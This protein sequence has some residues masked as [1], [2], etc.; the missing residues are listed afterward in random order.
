M[1]IRPSVIGPKR[2]YYLFEDVPEDVEKLLAPLVPE[3]KAVHS[4]HDAHDSDFDAVVSFAPTPTNLAESL[5][6]LSFGAIELS[7][8][9][10]IPGLGDQRYTLYLGEG[11]RSDIINLLE[12]AESGSKIYDLVRDTV[13]PAIKDSYRSWNMSFAEHPDRSTLPLISRGKEERLHAFITTR[14]TIDSER[15][16][17]LIVALPAETKRPDLWLM[18]FQE[19]LHLRN[20]DIFPLA[21]SWATDDPRWLPIEAERLLEKKRQSEA[22][23]QETAQQLEREIQE[24]KRELDQVLVRDR[25]T[26]IQR[27]LTAQGDDLTDAVKE[28]LETLGYAVQ[29]MDAPKLPGEPRLE[30]LRITLPGRKDWTVL[31]EVKGYKNDA[32]VNDLQQLP[33]RPLRKFMEETKLPP[34]S[35][36]H[37]V[38][39]RIEENPSARKRAHHHFNQ[40][41]TT[42]IAEHEGLILETRDLF[43]A[44]KAIQRGDHTAE[45]LRE[46]IEASEL[47][48][49]AE[50]GLTNSGHGT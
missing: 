29:D 31:A 40:E 45:E 42:L 43:E 28:A 34:S 25:A 17:G 47:Y 13:L 21:D 44:V 36:W 41:D 50:N 4:P 2:P 27:L 6:I 48:W 15:S 32:K 30:D 35:L 23:L 18:Q 10:C 38:N 46:A 16:R 22:E 49:T 9:R 11:P 5:P 1:S 14:R 7:F 33:G 24:T 8:L 20:P 26:G 37:I 3:Y 12:P 39:T 19:L